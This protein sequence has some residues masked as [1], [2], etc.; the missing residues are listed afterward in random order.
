MEYVWLCE[1]A[2]CRGQAGVGVAMEEFALV[3]CKNEVCP[4]AMGRGAGCSNCDRVN[5]CCWHARTKCVHVHHVE[6]QAGVG[7]A[8]GICVGCMQERGVS[9]YIMLGGGQA[10][11][12]VAIGI[13]VGGMQEWGASTSIG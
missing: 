7:V 10:A 3:A 8:M 9:T 4:H 2:L 1:F 6:G 5:L 11:V 13:R 12:S